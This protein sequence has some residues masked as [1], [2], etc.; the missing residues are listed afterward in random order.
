[1]TGHERTKSNKISER[2]QEAL[3]MHHLHRLAKIASSDLDDFFR[4]RSETGYVYRDRRMLIC[5]CQGAARH[6]VHQ[7]C[8]VK[9]FDVWA[10][11]RENPFRPFPYRRRGKQ[12]FGVSRFGRHPD[13]EGYQGR[14]VDVM[15]RSISA[16][17]DNG[18]AIASANG[19]AMARQEFPRDSEIPR[20]D[21]SPRSRYRE[22]HLEPRPGVRP[23]ASR[24]GD[25]S[26]SFRIAFENDLEVHLGI[27][28]RRLASSPPPVR[29]PRT[30]LMT[31][32][33]PSSSCGAREGMS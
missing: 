33:Q 12:D 8:G 23:R 16:A 15:G 24:P 21:H 14:R 31:Q 1:M 6:F 30:Q 5:L 27:R 28:R 10:F 13:D 4:R 2:S 25:T 7:N 9:D 17:V 3:E 11:F 19:F 26:T 18:H 29:R 32:G 20:C 22:D